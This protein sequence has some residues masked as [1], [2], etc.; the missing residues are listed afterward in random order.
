MVLPLG[1]ISSST[2]RIMMDCMG[3][4]VLK[5]HGKGYAQLDTRCAKA[6]Q[7]ICKAE[8][9]GHSKNFMFNKYVNLL[10]NAFMELKECGDPYPEWKKVDVFVKGLKAD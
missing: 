9:M 3:I 6:K 10:Q 7:I 2:T 4:H 1:A 8:Y 5:H